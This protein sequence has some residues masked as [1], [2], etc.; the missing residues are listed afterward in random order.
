MGCSPSKGNNFGTLASLRKGRMLPPVPVEGAGVSQLQN[1]DSRNLTESTNVDTKEKKTAAHI[2]V[3]QKE[4]QMTPQKKKHVVEQVNM[5]TGIKDKLEN[6]MPLQRRE[7]IVDKQDLVD[8][9]PVKKTRKNPKSAKAPK[10]KDKDKDNLCTDQKVDF[11][12]PLVIAHQAAYTFLNPSIQKYDVLLGLLEQATQTQISVQ[13][14]VAFMASRYKEMIQALEDIAD[15]GEK[16][17]KEN[18]GHLAWP[19][20]TKP[21]TSSAPLKSGSAK[22]EPPPDLLQQLLQYTTQRMRNVS[23]TI[24]GIGDT[25]L[26]EAVEYFASVSELLEEKLKVKHAVEARLMQLLTRIEMASLRKPGP[27]DS[28]L[29]SEDS[30]IGA[31]NESL[32]GSEK[33]YRRESCGSTGTTRTNI[34]HTEYTSMNSAALSRQK[35][36][37]QISPSVSLTSL[38][39]LGST[40]TIMPNDLRDS[41]LGSVSLDEGDDDIDEEDVDKGVGN[42]KVVFRKQSNASPVNSEKHPHRLPPKRIENPQNVEMTLKMK[43]AISGRINFV[44]TQNVSAKPKAA[45]SPKVTRREWTGDEVKSPRRP[46]TA[47]PVRRALVKKAAVNREQRSRSAESLRSKGEDPTRLELERTQKDLHQRLQ[48]MNKSKGGGNSR[49]G[50]FKQNEGKSPAQSPAMNHKIPPLDKSSNPQPIKHKEGF[51]IYHGKKPTQTGEL[52]EDEQKEKKTSKGPVKATPPPSP[53]ASPRPSSRLQRGRNSV[54]KLIDTFSQGIEE[55]D[56]P[57]VL[58]PLKGVRRCGVPILPGLG[59]VEAVLSS[60]ITS[61]RP[62]AKTSEKGDYLDLDSLPPPPL[63]VLMDTS[64][65]SHPSGSNAAGDGA[66]KVGRSPVLKRAAVPQRLRASVQ[67]GTVLP[68]K[69]GLPQSS[70]FVSQSKLDQQ[71]TTASPKVSQSDVQSGKRPEMET[72]SLSQEA[73]MI[74]HQWKSSDCNSDNSSTSQ[75]QLKDKQCG[76]LSVP[77]PITT[78]STVPYSTVITNQPPATPPVS[79]VR[80]LPATPSTPSSFHQRLCS[81]NSLRKPPTPPSS[82]SPTVGRTLPT[83]PAVQRRLPSSPLTKQKDLISKSPSP[84]SF[85]APSPP[86][87][88]KVQ[89]WSR[90]NSGEDSPSSRMFSNA[91]SV[92]C[93]MSASMFEAQPCSPAQAWAS[94]RVTIVSS[95]SGSRGRISASIQGPRPFVRRTQSDRRRSLCLPPRPQGCS[96]AETCGSEPAI[97]SKG[98][99]D[100]PTRDDELWGSRSDLSSTPRSASHPDLCVVGQALHRD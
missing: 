65:E 72:D 4:A 14:M 37:T 64:F 17:L 66:T 42:M 10:K 26:E 6:S 94:T 56:G 40:C 71:D 60:G 69:R 93:P 84:H 47:A 13:P 43:N 67:S 18:G 22:T 90:E 23:R 78:D 76:N 25:A 51:Q 15:E 31:E 75:G 80:M 27:E 9:K 46:Q 58:G 7:K 48:K 73:R 39:S 55:L 82:A 12:E 16:V 99:D 32:A 20:Q 85:K 52:D 2:K 11:P 92:F 88:P 54:K 83:P 62:E 91:R 77:G 19:V 50:S 70:K 45:D 5:E 89:R 21:P 86:A 97:Y 41:L 29:F 3:A 28:A 44:P 79:R 35:C 53:P 100:E 24:G 34:S 96:V 30:G 98:L 1:E 87:S 36:R 57:K 61:C 63:E 68:S 33:R 38:N 8:K 81:P 95:S 49:T 74:A 59:N